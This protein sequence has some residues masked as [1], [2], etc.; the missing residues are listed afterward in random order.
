[1]K[2]KTVI[3]LISIFLL[4]G[5]INDIKAQNNP[6]ENGQKDFIIGETET[7]GVLGANSNFALEEKDL[8][9]DMIDETFAKSVIKKYDAQLKNL[10]I[11]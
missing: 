2:T 11:K 3:L 6:T 10:H 1:M 9:D 7:T 5:M 8:S 4:T